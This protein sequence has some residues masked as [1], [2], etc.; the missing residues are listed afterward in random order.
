MAEQASHGPPPRRGELGEAALGD[1]DR[2]GSRRVRRLAAR[3]DPEGD[4]LERDRRSRSVGEKGVGGEGPD[5]GAR[6][7]VGCHPLRPRHEH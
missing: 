5:E 7:H 2:L 3:G 1:A 6:L 4:E